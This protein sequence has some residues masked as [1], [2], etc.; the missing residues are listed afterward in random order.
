VLKGSGV[1]RELALPV[2][3]PLAGDSR[4]LRVISTGPCWWLEALNVS[5]E[6]AAAASRW[7]GGMSSLLNMLIVVR[8]R[9]CERNIRRSSLKYVRPGNGLFCGC[10]VTGVTRVNCVIAP[11]GRY[12]M[13]SQARRCV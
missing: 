13:R 11:Q 9:S 5:L 8:V 3:G 10:T 7:C 6:G 4:G 2:V 1:A 12:T